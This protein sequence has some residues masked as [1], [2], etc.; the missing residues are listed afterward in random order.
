MRR[1]EDGGIYLLK[2]YR[3]AAENGPF[4]KPYGENLGKDAFKLT[5]VRGGVGGF[6]DSPA[7][8]VC[9]VK[10]KSYVRSQSTDA[11]DFSRDV[12]VI[13]R[14]KETSLQL[15]KISHT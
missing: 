9:L 1:R 3:D 8:P 12:A 2:L 4:P 11:D 13:L 5:R 7:V 15:N 10:D 6:Y 14:L